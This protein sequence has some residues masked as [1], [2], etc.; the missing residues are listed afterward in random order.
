[1]ITALSWVPRGHAAPFPRKYV[2]NEEEYDRISKLAKLELDEAKDDL[3]EARGNKPADD[4]DEDADK[5][6]RAEAKT[7][8]DRDDDDDMFV[9]LYSCF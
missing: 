2:F 1:M 9:H 3:A 4:D 7:P 8:A 5:T 6:T